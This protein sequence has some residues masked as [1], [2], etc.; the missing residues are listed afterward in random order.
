MCNVVPEC[1]ERVVAWP[2]NVH[3]IIA[4]N[5]NEPGKL[6]GE[7]N[8][9]FLGSNYPGFLLKQIRHVTDDRLTDVL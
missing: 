1:I 7:T 8:R 6:S 3:R 4:K 5:D 2:L 9:D